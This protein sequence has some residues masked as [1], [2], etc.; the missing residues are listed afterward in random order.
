METRRWACTERMWLAVPRRAPF[1]GAVERGGDQANPPLSLRARDSRWD[2]GRLGEGH[3]GVR[4]PGDP[5]TAGPGLGAAELV[6]ISIHIP[7]LPVCSAEGFSF[8]DGQT[9]SQSRAGLR[10]IVRTRVR[11]VP[12]AVS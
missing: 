8:L 11:K 2:L 12:K 6:T 10:L 7:V 5:W 1:R 3:G 4:D 9:A